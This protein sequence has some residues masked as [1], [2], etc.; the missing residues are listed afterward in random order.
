[1]AIIGTSVNR[2]KCCLPLL[3]LTWL[4]ATIPGTCWGAEPYVVAPV[5]S[6]Q[7]L[8][9]L[10]TSAW[11]PP[12]GS[13]GE[14]VLKLSYL[15]GLLDALQY[16]QVAPKSAAQVLGQLKGQGLND[17]AVAIDQYYLA[18]P[19]HRELPPAVVLLR[20]LPQQAQSAAPGAAQ[21]APGP[22]NA[23]PKAP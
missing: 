15:R 23:P 6:S 16:A 12:D 21:G 2:L 4:A 5:Q 3:L 8:R 19:G 20:I 18:D 22:A 9:L 7:D 14:L 10:A 17:L 13:E 11:P 1:M